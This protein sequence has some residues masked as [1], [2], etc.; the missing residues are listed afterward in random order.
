MPFYKSAKTKN[1]A[2]CIICPKKAKSPEQLFYCRNAL[3]FRAFFQFL[4]YKYKQVQYQVSCRI[5]HF[6]A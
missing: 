5:Q 4:L 2:V 1:V 6:L 3:Q